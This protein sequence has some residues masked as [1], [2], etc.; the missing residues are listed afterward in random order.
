MKYLKFVELE[1]TG[2]TRRVAVES[3]HTNIQLGIIKWWSHWRRYCF[4]PEPN[5][6]W[7]AECM[8]QIQNQLSSMMKEH[9]NSKMLKMMITG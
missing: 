4:F 2:L 3:K 5:T 9:K 7:S 8:S 6:L 1:K